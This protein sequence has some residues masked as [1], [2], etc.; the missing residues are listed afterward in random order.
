VA[1]DHTLFREALAGILTNQPDME[2]VGEARDGLEAVVKAH[3]LQPDLVLMDVQMPGLDGIE[4]TRQIRQALPGTI[5]VM[6]TVC[7]DEE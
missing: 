4:A 1:D 7:D 6:L 2:V 5:V 3:A